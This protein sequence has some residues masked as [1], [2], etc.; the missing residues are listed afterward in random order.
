L[1][2]I[3]PQST[4]NAPEVTGPATHEKEILG[5]EIQ[6]CLLDLT[7]ESVVGIDNA[8]LNVQ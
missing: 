1:D 8:A 4:D 6:N 3:G 2:G 5:P 7:L